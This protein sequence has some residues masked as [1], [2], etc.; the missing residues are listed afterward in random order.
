[1][2]ISTPGTNSNANTN[3]PNGRFSEATSSA[4]G[5]IDHAAASTHQAINKV[6]EAVKPVE[7]W[8]SEKTSALMTAP[9]NAAADA[10][11]FIVTHPWQSVG[12]AVLA[13]VLL[14]RRTR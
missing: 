4:H 9:K 12:V 8:V 2:E 10:R 13:G 11:Q 5:A 6:E 7:R 14:G 3:P 1:M